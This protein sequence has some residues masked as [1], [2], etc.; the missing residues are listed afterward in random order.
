[1]PYDAHKYQGFD[2]FWRVMVSSVLCQSVSLVLVYPLDLIHTRTC[3]DMTLK[4]NPRLY[5]TTF[6]C[7]NRTNLDEARMGL[8]K[9]IEV[10]AFAAVLR[11]CFQLPVYE[12]V[13]RFEPSDNKF[14]QRVGSAMVSGM[15]MGLFLYPFDT[16]KRSLQLNGGRGFMTLYKSPVDCIT[17]FSASPAMIWRGAPLYL[18]TSSLASLS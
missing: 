1:M 15:L 14:A 8:F 6:D 4:G 5:T 3:A 9:G 10:A 13:K 11:S 18:L 16:M 17:K 12:L 7:F 2:Y